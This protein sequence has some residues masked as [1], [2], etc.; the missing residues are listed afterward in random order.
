VMVLHEIQGLDRSIKDA[1]DRLAAAGYVAY[2]PDIY[3]RGF[4]PFC[5]VR[6]L[7]ALARGDPAPVT[8]LTDMLQWLRSQPSTLDDAIAVMGFCMGGGFA[9][10]LAV[11]SAT[12]RA[13]S[14][15]YGGVPESIDDVR[16]V[17]PVVAS[18]GAEDQ[19][20]AAEGRRLETFLDELGIDHDVRI[21]DGATHS[22]MNNHHGALAA[23]LF[24][25]RFH[26]E[27]ADD[28]WNRTLEFFERHL[29]TAYAAGGPEA[30]EGQA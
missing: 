12:T 3:S 27:A 28:A 4:K 6:T 19:R 7:R 15:N 30:G 18:Y 24:G 8:D 29:H 17:C 10:S 9:L 21:Y 23:R 5:I 13:A 11:S 16:G 22:F 2:A 26:P 20:F 14:V 25:V 1:C